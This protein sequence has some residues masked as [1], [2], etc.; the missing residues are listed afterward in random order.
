MRVISAK[1]IAALVTISDIIEAVDAVMRVVSERT[2]NLPIRQVMEIAPGKR[3][4]LMPG[5]ISDPPAFGIKLLSL[6]AGNA[7]RGLSSH[8]G[9]VMLFD[10]ETGLPRACM[11]AALVTAL[12]TS[13]ASAVATRVLAPA[14]I[15]KLAIIG[16]GEEAGAHLAA[17]RAVRTPGR[18]EVW[19]R[20]PAKAAA[21]AAAHE[22]V[23]VASS[24]AAALEG[25]ALVCTTTSA[26]EVLVQPGM[27]ARGAHLNAA[28][29]TR[30][31]TIE[32]SPGCYSEMTLFADYLP[33]LEE[34]AL[35]Y[36]Q[37]RELGI[38]P[39]GTAVEIGD[40]LRGVHPG[41]TSAEERTMYRSLGIAAQD[42]ASA[43][44]VL[45]RA[46]QAGRGTVVDLS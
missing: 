13:A 24:V 40:V 22:G 16:T 30:P 19:G 3:L 35:D 11:D 8:T 39:A 17:M 2:V 21:F 12:R 28:G 34:E 5:A 20:D 32:I 9:V 10:M 42:L 44:L 15:E 37:A 33:A 45:E 31:P 4:G 43:C 29:A 7:A 36:I 23:T 6:F 1:D 18:V 41:R 26:R 25:A 27:L 46:E 14:N 38:I